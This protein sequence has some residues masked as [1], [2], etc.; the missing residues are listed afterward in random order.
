MTKQCNT[1][2]RYL[3]KSAFAKNGKG[4][5]SKCRECQSEYH[6]QWRADPENHER[7]KK[8]WIK[9]SKRLIATSPH[10]RQADRLRGINRRIIKDIETVRNGTCI[11]NF[12]CSKKVFVARFEILCKE[13]WYDLKKN[14]RAWQI[15]WIT[16]NLFKRVYVRYRIEPKAANHYTNLRP[17]WGTANLKK[18]A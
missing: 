4:L 1:C 18:T 13:S 7:L 11:D 17:V 3:P 15:T 10:R 8:Y 2:Y 12:G 16:L 5:H 6:K 14:H 9:T